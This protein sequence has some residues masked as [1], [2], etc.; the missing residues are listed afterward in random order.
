MPGPP[1]RASPA[2]LPR[3]PCW[4]P[5]SGPGPSRPAASGRSSRPSATGGPRSGSCRS[6]T[7]STA[8]SA[9][10][11][12]CSSSTTWRS[13]ARSSSRSGCA[14]PPCPAAA[15]TRSSGSTP[16]SR[17]WARPTRSCAPGRGPC[18]RPTT[19]PVPA[20]SLPNGPRPAPRPS[21]RPGPPPTSGSRSWPTRS[22]TIRP[23]GPGS[24]SS[25]RPGAELP[26]GWRRPLG[27]PVTDRTTLAFAVRNEPGT[28]LSVLRVLADR[29]LNLST[30][31]SRPSRQVAWEYVFWADVDA[32][33]LAPDG[34][35]ALAEIRPLTTMVRVLGAYQRAATAAGPESGR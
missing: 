30:L 10:S 7:S 28:L 11:T 13:S 23:T 1:S 35:A 24:S 26:G 6:R 3:T 8:P 4:P 25:A 17:R 33:L 2:R 9:R 16:T 32:D 21:S 18:S 19:R 29:Q 14:W 5:S 34:A 15:S 27:A 20:S 22:R 12:T 31:E